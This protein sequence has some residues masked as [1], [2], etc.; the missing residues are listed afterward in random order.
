MDEVIV[1]VFTH[2]LRVLAVAFESTRL[3]YWLLLTMPVAFTSLFAPE[4]FLM[5]LPSLAINTL[6]SNTATYTP[7][8]FHYTAPIVPFIVVASLRGVARLSRWLG[9]G[10]EKRR[11]T[12]CNRLLIVV[13][14]A[15]L[16]YHLMA[17]YTPLR[18]GFR[19]PVPDAHDVLAKQMVGTIPPQA[20][21]SAANSLVPRLAN[22]SRIYI[23]PKIEEAEYIAV[24]TQSSY[25]PFGDRQEL[26]EAA[27]QL[28]A[29]SRYGVIFF[30]D[31]LLLLRRGAPD[32]VDVAPHAVC[33][34]V[35]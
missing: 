31:G 13:F 1:N 8:M 24:D 5:A 25:Y 17:G 28:M 14:G 32:Q 26:C 22:R 11:S 6:S 18:L 7:D 33:P 29:G 9:R 20:S 12:W 2:P 4:I 27:R 10:D 3:P 15:S 35:P 21:V 30:S 19:W 16:A 34:E 23:F